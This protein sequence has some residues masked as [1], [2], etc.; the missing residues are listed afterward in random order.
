[1]SA[2]RARPGLFITLEGCEG[3]GKSTQQR[4]LQRRLE[5]LGLKVTTTRE[6]GGTVLGGRI[7]DI[8]RRPSNEPFAP[9]TELL[10]YLADRAQHLE[11]VV[12]PALAQNQVVVSDRFTDSTEVYQGIARG[13]GREEV[14][15]LNL[16]L[17]QDIWPDL[18]LLLDLDPSTGLERI[19]SSRGED[20]MDRLENEE[21]GFHLKLRQ[22]F[23][24]QAAAEPERIQV[25]P[26][27]LSPDQVA[28]AIWSHVE[29]LVR[30]WRGH[31]G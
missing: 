24:D 3:V 15:R 31:E 8:V 1:M 6:P 27:H 28:D 19:R 12:G 21:L 9:K 30:S 18:T 22:G 2:V 16:W 23:L 14:R 26:A 17:C 10:L 25:V 7:R 4:M 13:L 11:R 20:N 5:G 29:P